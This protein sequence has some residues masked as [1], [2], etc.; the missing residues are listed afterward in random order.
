MP[1]ADSCVD[2]CV[3]ACI[4]VPGC[5]TPNTQEQL[6]HTAMLITTPSLTNLNRRYGNSRVHRLAADGTHV[7]PPPCRVCP[8]VIPARILLL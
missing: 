8:S 3:R 7:C 1:V 4:D 2:T 6:Q 5:G